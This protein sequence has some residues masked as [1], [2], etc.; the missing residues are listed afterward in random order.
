MS[1]A[2]RHGLVGERRVVFREQG[3]TSPANTLFSM[4]PGDA[5]SREC[6]SAMAETVSCVEKIAL[7]LAR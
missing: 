5:S 3:N 2:R 6:T 1:R 7:Y 4:L